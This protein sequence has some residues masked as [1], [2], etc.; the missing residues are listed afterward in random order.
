ML[1][2]MGQNERR[3]MAAAGMDAGQLAVVIIASKNKERRPDDNLDAYNIEL[4]GRKKMKDG[5]D[6]THGIVRDDLK[7]SEQ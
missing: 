4:I 7:L 3:S 1:T 6:N 2:D 5:S